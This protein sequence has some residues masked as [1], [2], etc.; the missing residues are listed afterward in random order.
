MSI[1]ENAEFRLE[2]DKMLLRVED[3]DDK[4]REYIVVSIVP[5]GQTGNRKQ[6]DSGPLI[7]RSAGIPADGESDLFQLL[8][9]A[10]PQTTLKRNTLNNLG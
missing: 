9:L 1:G 8:C 6:F 5:K 3:M 10:L 4:E 7:G 2:K